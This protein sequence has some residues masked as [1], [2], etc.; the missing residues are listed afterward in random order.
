MRALAILGVLV[1]GVAFGFTGFA[2]ALFLTSA[3]ALEFAPAQVVPAVLLVGDTVILALAWEHRRSLLARTLRHVPPFAPWSVVFLIMGL[4]SGTLLLSQ[5]PA[6]VGRLT[7][8]VV[9]LVFVAFQSWRL[10]R[11]RRATAR[12]GVGVAARAEGAADGLDPLEQVTR[13][14]AALAALA[15]GILDGWLGTGGVAIAMYLTWRQFPPD[16]FVAGMR[17]Y[18]LASDAIRIV[19][20]A[21]GGYWTR[22][23]LELYL[24][25]IPIALPAALLGVL[26]RRRWG[27]REVFRAA[28]LVVLVFYALALIVRA[29]VEG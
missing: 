15:A 4:V 17:G 3:L 29:G 26:A 28:V 5:A 6:M 10:A 13:G 19:L 16:P 25:T 9:V 8:A 11:E 24:R 14:P 7:L 1:G 27:T 12:V 20:Y 21:F 22:A 18:F 2:F 23:A